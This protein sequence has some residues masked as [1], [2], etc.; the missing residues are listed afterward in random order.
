[1]PKK[2]VI[3][4]GP[5]TGK[6]SLINQLEIKGFNCKHEISREVTL[7]AKEE[8]IDQLFLEDPILFS[9][10]L[11]EGRLEQFKEGNNS[12]KKILFYDRGLPDVTAYM[13][14]LGTKYPQSFH[15]TC[16]ANRY[17][18]V[19]ILPPW[20]EIY[21]QDNERYETFIE[22]K[23]IYS[24]LISSYKKYNYD[25]YEIPVGSIEQRIAYILNHVNKDIIE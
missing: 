6:T 18:K 24:F 19:F 12:A 7:K 23:N 4:G 15:D 11:L 1:M 9:Q 2:I 21:M 25:V 14:F 10:K 5:G 22:A 8:G 20:E 3:T 17:H 13:D 16:L